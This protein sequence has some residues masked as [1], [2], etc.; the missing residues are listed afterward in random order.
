MN[1][2]SY[3]PGQIKEVQNTFKQAWRVEVI[4]KHIPAGL[5][6][7]RDGIGPW[8]FSTVPSIYFSAVHEM[9][10]IINDRWS[11]AYKWHAHLPHLIENALTGP[12][13]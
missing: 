8:P 9:H 1:R 5:G 7:R 3:P 4:P 6:G 10:T 13:C 11:S 2:N 12:G